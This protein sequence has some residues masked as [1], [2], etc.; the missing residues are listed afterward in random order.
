MWVLPR[1]VPLTETLL[2]IALKQQGMATLQQLKTGFLTGLM[3][4]VNQASYETYRYRLEA[5]DVTFVGLW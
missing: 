3:S 5:S 1:P 2:F 4:T